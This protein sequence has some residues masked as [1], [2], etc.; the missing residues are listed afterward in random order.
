MRISGQLNADLQG[1]LPCCS[2]VKKKTPQ[3]NGNA[4]L[5]F[6]VFP[7]GK[8]HLQGCHTANRLSLGLFAI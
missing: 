8:A 5:K 1:I 6:T 2:E 4:G 7:V 3:I